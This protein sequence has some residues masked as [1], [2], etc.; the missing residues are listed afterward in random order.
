[1]MQRRLDLSKVEVKRLNLVLLFLI[2]TIYLTIELGV[3]GTPIRKL[4]PVL[5]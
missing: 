5:A 3:L 1:M 2:Q 4:N